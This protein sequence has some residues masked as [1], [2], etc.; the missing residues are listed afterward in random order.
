VRGMQELTMKGDEES[1][2]VLSAV[3]NIC[4]GGSVVVRCWAPLTR[5]N[6]IS[7][8]KKTIDW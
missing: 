3:Y 4:A 5:S 2:R 7:S 8:Q 6:E 1:T